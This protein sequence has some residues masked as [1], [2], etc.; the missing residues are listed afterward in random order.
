MSYMGITL[1]NTIVIQN[2]VFLVWCLPYKSSSS[3]SNVLYIVHSIYLAIRNM[4][5]VA[6]L[7]VVWALKP[8]DLRKALRPRRA[9]ICCNREFQ[10]CQSSGGWIH[11]PVKRPFLFC[12]LFIDITQTK[13]NQISW[14]AWKLENIGQTK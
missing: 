1:R 10:K 6:K 12:V 3:G 13:F 2:K 4:A 11:R 14:K 8:V 7:N 9:S 5:D